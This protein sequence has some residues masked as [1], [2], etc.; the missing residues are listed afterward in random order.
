MLYWAEGGK[1]RNEVRLTNSDP[2]MIRLFLAFLRRYYGVTHDRVALSINCYLN[3]GLE[4]EEVENWWLDQL[5]LPRSS[6]RR[7]HVGTPRPARRSSH[8]VLVHGTARLTVCSTSLIQSIYGGIQEY[9]GV[10]GYRWVD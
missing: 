4:L 2:D 5:G 8:T 10:S 6:L 7:S 1:T 3:N 9:A